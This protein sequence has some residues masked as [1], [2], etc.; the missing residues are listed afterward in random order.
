MGGTF[1]GTQI[2]QHCKYNKKS[3]NKT[4]D[5][6]RDAHYIVQYYSD[7]LLQ[8]RMPTQLQEYINFN[9]LSEDFFNSRRKDS[10]PELQI[11]NPKINNYYDFYTALSKLQREYEKPDNTHVE[12]RQKI[13]E[14]LRVGQTVLQLLIEELWESCDIQGRPL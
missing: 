9:E 2:A 6:I 13:T 3:F 5:V 11:V 7:I 14:V 12:R 1:S 8:E 4:L 10:I